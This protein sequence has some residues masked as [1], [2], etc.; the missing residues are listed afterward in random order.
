MPMRQLMR[1]ISSMRGIT[2]PPLDRVLGLP[3]DPYYLDAGAPD[4]W[5]EEASARG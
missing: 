2:S 1:Q 5:R 4:L 3:K